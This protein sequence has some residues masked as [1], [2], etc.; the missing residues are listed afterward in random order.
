MSGRTALVGA[1]VGVALAV[2]GNAAAVDHVTLFVAPTTLSQ[3]GWK[4]SAAVAGPTE[5]SR[6]ETFGI[7]LTRTFGNG[8]QEQHGLRAAPTGTVSFDGRNGRWRAR[9]GAVA[10]IDMT[11][12]ASGPVRELGEFQGCRGD[13]V[14]QP[15]R[16]RGSFVLRTGTDFFGTI[17]RAL[18][19]GSVTFNRGGPIDCAAPPAR[20]CSPSSVLT[21]VRD[22]SRGPAAALM[23]SPDGGGWLTLTFADRGGALP[24]GV[25]WY[26]VLRAERLGFDPLAGRPPSIAVELPFGLAV[27]GSGT[28][29]ASETST[30]MDGACRRTAATGI[31]TG[32]FRTRFAGWGPRTAAFGGSGNAGFAEESA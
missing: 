26:H 29:A 12:A 19:A 10:A 22:G 24:A 7:S 23:L 4:L 31:F 6:R 3:P 9:F 17:R 14:T 13:F 32:S 8:R 18:L 15:V 28:F 11:L 2:P 21:V 1:V 5:Q 30:G 20:T 16:L 25:T 27:R